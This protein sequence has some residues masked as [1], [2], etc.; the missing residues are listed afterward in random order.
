[1]SLPFAPTLLT[2]RSAA[3]VVARPAHWRAGIIA[4]V[5]KIELAHIGAAAD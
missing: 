5:A 2:P 1:M 4:R 3:V